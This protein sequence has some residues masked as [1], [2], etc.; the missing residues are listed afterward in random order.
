MRSKI[1]ARVKC[2]IGPWALSCLPSMC[3]SRAP[4][5]FTPRATARKTLIVHRQPMTS[6]S[7]L[8]TRREFSLGKAAEIS[9]ALAVIILHRKVDIPSNV[10]TY[11]SAASEQQLPQNSTRMMKGTTRMKL[12]VIFTRSGRAALDSVFAAATRLG[13]DLVVFAKPTS[14]RAKRVSMQRFPHVLP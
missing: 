8:S 14:F 5:G 2:R 4:G 6:S 13:L 10:L 12:I 3:H 9:F 1:P 11:A 7:S